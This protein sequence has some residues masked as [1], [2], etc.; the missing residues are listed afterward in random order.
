MRKFTI[1]KISLLTS[2]LILIFNCNSSPN[3]LE[4]A[5]NKTPEDLSKTILFALQ[6]NDKELY[7]SLISTEHEVKFFIDKLEMNPS[8][9]K[10]FMSN[11]PKMMNSFDVIMATAKS[12]GLTDWNNVEYSAISY[13]GPIDALKTDNF[14]IDFTNG[15]YIGKL[16]IGSIIRS[17]R[18]WFIN[19]RPMFW[20]YYKEKKSSD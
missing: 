8:N 1:T 17:D 10:S 6:N 19:R 7:N 9:L 14:V 13:Q 15:E 11:H 2:I 20:K 4:N 5:G 3:S 12:Y 16:N 18:G